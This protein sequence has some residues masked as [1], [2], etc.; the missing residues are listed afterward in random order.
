MILSVLWDVVMM[1]VRAFR[2][3]GEISFS[4]W[5][6]FGSKRRVVGQLSQ[7]FG[8]LVLCHGKA[9]REKWNVSGWS[10]TVS[11]RCTELVVDGCHF[12]S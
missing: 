2:N 3:A 1:W 8:D 10:L 12:I 9:G 6:G 11:R 4:S 5:E 7:N